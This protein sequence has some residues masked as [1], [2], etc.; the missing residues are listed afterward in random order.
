MADKV[1][2]M[3]PGET[4]EIR[5]LTHEDYDRNAKS[6]QDQARPQSDLIRINGPHSITPARMDLEFRHWKT[7]STSPPM[8]LERGGCPTCG[9]AGRVGPFFEGGLS[10]ICGN[11]QAPSSQPK[12]EGKP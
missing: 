12:M 11:C 2:Y 6:W 5:H 8:K 9:G 4:L 1:I 7:W 3:R 10:T